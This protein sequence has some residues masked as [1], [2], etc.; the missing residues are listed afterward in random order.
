MKKE[1]LYGVGGLIIG[2]VIAVAVTWAITN[3]QSTSSQMH[4]MDATNGKTGDD[5]DKAYLDTMISHLEM[6]VDIAKQAG[7]SAKHDQIK[8]AAAQLIETQSRQIDAMKAWQMDW[9]YIINGM[10]HRQMHH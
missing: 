6:S 7:T 5:F 2:S 3:N 1:L 10:N 4:N 8:I 9:G